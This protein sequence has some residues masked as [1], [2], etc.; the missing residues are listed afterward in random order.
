MKPLL[1]IGRTRLRSTAVPKPRWSA[2]ERDKA[3]TELQVKATSTS[4]KSLKL[5]KTSAVERRSQ[6]WTS[7]SATRR[8]QLCTIV[9]EHTGTATRRHRAQPLGQAVEL[10]Q[11]AF[12]DAP[13]RPKAV[14]QCLCMVLYIIGTVW[15]WLAALYGAQSH[16]V[17]GSLRLSTVPHA[18][19]H[20][21]ASFGNR[22]RSVALDGIQ[23]RFDSIFL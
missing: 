23:Q 19:W 13:L 12:A 15:S 11:A 9:G 17:A 5:F 2:N 6:V 20:S 7:W 10:Q 22:R 14:L 1:H 21:L 3:P 4:G 18:L 16:L 8:C